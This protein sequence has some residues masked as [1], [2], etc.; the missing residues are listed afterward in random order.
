MGYTVCDKFEGYILSFWSHEC[1]KCIW[2]TLSCNFDKNE[3]IVKKLKFDVSR[4]T[5]RMYMHRLKLVSQSM[6]QKTRK[7]WCA[8]G[9]HF[10]IIRPCSNSRDITSPRL[11]GNTLP[12]PWWESFI[13]MSGCVGSVF[14]I[15][16]SEISSLFNQLRQSTQNNV[17]IQFVTY[18]L[19][20]NPMWHKLI[21]DCDVIKMLP[22]NAIL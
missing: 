15:P 18:A 4:H 3:L 10:G 12:F 8:G 16:I 5:Y 7:L 9:Q 2:L 11:R 1:R 6:L 21:F 14:N 20:H 17:I 19:K 22:E 13:T